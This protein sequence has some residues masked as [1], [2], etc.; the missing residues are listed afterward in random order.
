MKRT[1]FLSL[2]L[3]LSVSY[4]SSQTKDKPT[5][6]LIGSKAPSFTAETTNGDLRFPEDFG[7]KWKVLFSHP[8]DF[9]PV[10]TSEILELSKMQ[11]QLDKLGIKVAILSTDTKELHQLWKESMEDILSTEPMPVKIKFPFI[12]D[13]KAEISKLYGMLHAPVSTTRDVRGVFI[14][15]PD[16]VVEATY[17]YPMA[18]GRNMEELV[19]TVQ[20][21]QTAQETKL[22]TPANWVPGKDLLVPYHPLTV[23]EQSN[24]P[25]LQNEF[26]NKGS[27]LWYK[28]FTE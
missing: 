11:N 8:R 26:Y 18:I 1:V 19:R 23:E 5:I 13:A 22:F 6:P 9:T 2:I 16:N 3:L 12:D 14:I 4:L 25:E 17:F 24:K 15:N 27:F 21:L 10:C 28:K 7:R 20:A